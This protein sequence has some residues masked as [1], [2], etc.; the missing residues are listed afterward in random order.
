MKFF[1]SVLLLILF[2]A[3][4]CFGQEMA[5]KIDKKDLKAF[6]KTLTSAQFEGRGI[7]TEGH[8][9][10]QAFIADRFE[11]LQLEPFSPD[12]YLEKFTLNRTYQ[13]DVYM[14]TQNGKTLL[15][16]DKMVILNG[17]GLQEETEKEVVF[18]GFGTQPE[19]EQ[20]DV[21][22]RFVV[23]SLQKPADQFDIQK[24]LGRLKASGLIVFHADDKRFESMK[25]TLKEHHM[26]KRYSLPNQ[27]DTLKLNPQFLALLDSIVQI[28]TITIPGAEA[29]N[30]MRLSKNRLT[31]LA[32]KN[33]IK[34]I[35]SAKIGVKFGRI[36]DTVE[37]ANVAGIIRGESEKTIVIS[38]HY[39]HVGKEGTTF[40]PGADDNASGV[41]ALLELAEEFAQ[42][43]DLKY[44]MVFLATSAEENGLLGSYYHVNRPGF[45]PEN[46]ICNINI[47][48][49]SRCDDKHADCRYLYCIG[50]NRPETLDSLIARADRHYPN[51][52]FD[53]SE[54]NSGL[55]SRSDSRSFMQKKIPSI[56]FFS[57]LHNDYH[58]P[59]DT[60]D[61]IDFD[62]LESRVRQIG[63]VIRMLQEEA[64]IFE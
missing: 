10:A 26:Q 14:K 28:N 34:Q 52:T 46:V 25:R 50:S 9:K 47:D 2:L 61:K 8:R 37:T 17:N 64:I 32:Q 29:K 27:R 33:K 24:R 62:I 44:T 22:G 3:G 31:K 53:Y 36:E 13:G 45:N 21:K 23:V 60:M 59:T 19:L 39:D 42:C 40:Y 20:I 18:G 11:A 48:M 1:L 51:C 35:P 6:L 41:A 7:D 38:A 56:L 5:S 30:I 55:A 43:N 58:K 63:V 4:S 16:F 54:N 15:N 57:G 49:I 12:G